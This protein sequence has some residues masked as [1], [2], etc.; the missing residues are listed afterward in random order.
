MTKNEAIQRQ[1]ETTIQY[2]R[3]RTSTCPVSRYLTV[4]G[5]ATARRQALRLARTMGTGWEHAAGD[6]CYVTD[7]HG[8][9]TR[10]V[11][12]DDGRHLSERIIPR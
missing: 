6:V 11:T 5:Y 3:R 12:S 8:V 4:A 7:A 10:L 1:L 2:D 9:I